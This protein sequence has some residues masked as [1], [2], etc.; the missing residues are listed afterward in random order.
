MELNFTSNSE[1]F[2]YKPW[3][4]KG[5]FQLEIITNDLGSSFALFEYLYYE[6]TA[7]LKV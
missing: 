3:G 4:S 1:I 5:F 2:V 6:S 7:F